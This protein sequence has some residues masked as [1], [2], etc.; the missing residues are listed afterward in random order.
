MGVLPTPKWKLEAGF[1][2]RWTPSPAL[3]TWP[4]AA[5]RAKHKVRL[6]ESWLS[7]AMTHLVPDPWDLIYFNFETEDPLKV[8][9]YLRHYVGCWA[10]APDGINFKFTSYDDPGHVYV[11]PHG[12]TRGTGL[13][14]QALVLSQLEKAVPLFPHVA[15]DSFHIGPTGLKGVLDAMRDGRI[16]VLH[17]PSLPATAPASYQALKNRMRVRSASLTGWRERTILVHEAVHAIVDFR[18]YRLYG[19]QNEFLAYTTHAVWGRA[20]DNARA[21]AKVGPHLMNTD[22]E[23]HAFILAR[24]LRGTGAR[25]L[26]VEPLDTLLPDYR[27]PTRNLNPVAGL[28]HAIASHPGYADTAGLIYKRDGF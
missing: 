14:F 28:T 21:E 2:P 20:A 13:P 23:H 24:Y 6:G 9:W 12:Y 17:D 8:N 5:W 4:P 26:K 11:P 15:F 1:K 18:K 3:A 25:T 7:V 16:E 10:A 27:D 19:W 22:I